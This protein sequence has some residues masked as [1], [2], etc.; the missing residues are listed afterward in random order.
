MDGTNYGTGW[1]NLDPASTTWHATGW[2][3]S[4]FDPSR[5]LYGPS[6]N[7]YTHTVNGVGNIHGISSTTLATGNIFLRGSRAAGT[8]HSGIFTL[9]LG[10][11]FSYSNPE[12]GF[13]CAR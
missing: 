13:R 12:L 8:G 10:L 11:S 4:V 2:N 3:A 1:T 6:S 7:N 5:K 9:N